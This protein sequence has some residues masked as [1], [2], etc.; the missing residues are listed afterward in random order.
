MTDVGIEKR[1]QKAKQYA[2]VM[3]R[4]KKREQS[5]MPPVPEP[6]PEPNFGGNR[7]R[8]EP[9]ARRVVIHLCTRE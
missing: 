8:V 5:P 6:A 9:F 7:V 2:D 1:A 4:V 3:E